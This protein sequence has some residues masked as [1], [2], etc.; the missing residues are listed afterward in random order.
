MKK[1]LAIISFAVI[2]SLLFGK[3]IFNFYK[4][5]SEK[6]SNTVEEKVYFIQQGAYSSEESANNN[7]KDLNFYII[8]KEETYYKV[9]VGITQNEEFSNKIK[10]I[11]SS[12]NKSIYVK[13]KIV[14]SLAFLEI[15]KQYDNLLKDKTTNDEILNIEKQVL[16]KYK[17][18]VLQNG[19]GTD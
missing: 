18:L 8:E 14:S 9:Y 10:E 1:F 11:Y 15:L 6:V 19:E 17:E 16:S 13:E 2:M 7:S 3:Y 4:E 12:M 5:T